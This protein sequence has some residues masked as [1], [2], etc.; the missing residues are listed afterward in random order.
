MVDTNVSDGNALTDEVKINLNMLHA[1]VL[2]EV[3]GEVDGADVVTIDQ[4]GLRQEAVQL[5]E[6]LTKPTRHW[7][8]HSTPPQCSNMRQ[9]SGASRTRK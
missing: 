5:H 4:S 3:S 8:R 2:D 6:Q 7:P 1:L 9:H